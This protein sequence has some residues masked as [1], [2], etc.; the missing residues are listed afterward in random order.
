MVA[1]TV[2]FALAKGVTM[3]RITAVTGLT[4]AD[5]LDPD[6]QL[7]EQHVPAIWRLLGERY[8]GQALS[9]EMA[10]AAPLTFFG[11]LAH[12]VRYAHNL[13]VA[14]RDLVRYRFVLSDRVRLSLD[15]VGRGDEV[16]MRMSHPTDAID[17]GYGIEVGTALASRFIRE[18]VGMPHALARVEF[19]H[20]RFAPIAAYEQFFGTPVHFEQPDSGFVFHRRAMS[21]ALPERD[22]SLYAFIQGHL[23]LAHER[24][25]AE[26]AGDDELARVRA[27]VADGAERGEYSAEALAHRLGMSLRALQRLTRAH[28]TSVRQLIDHAR[29]ASARELLRDRRL[30][31]EEI[32][33][34]LGYSDDRAFRRAFKRWTG[35]TP[36]RMRNPPD[37]A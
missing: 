23:A 28:D 22:P 25:V 12:G 17:G 18:I 14:L 20:A 24:L 19:A 2:M 1:S 7:P 16:M 34:L 29:E 36:A 32:A 13:E 27:A 11:T 35:H 4:R 3:E 21:E 10:A 8:P 31:V 37:G 33:Y 26:A 15:E 30:S 5:L 6:A 9:L